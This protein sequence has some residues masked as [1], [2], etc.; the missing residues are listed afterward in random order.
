MKIHKQLFSFVSIIARVGVAI[1]TDTKVDIDTVIGIWLFD[2][3]ISDD[4]KD[5]SGN[6]NDDIPIEYFEDRI[7]ILFESQQ[8]NK[9]Q[10]QKFRAFLSYRAYINGLIYVPYPTIFVFYYAI[11]AP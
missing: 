2:E 8:F 10:Q 7:L 4:V 1:P 3:G 11:F 9:Y 6:G 5:A